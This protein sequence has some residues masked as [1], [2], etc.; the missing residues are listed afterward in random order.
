MKDRFY[1]KSHNDRINGPKQERHENMKLENQKKNF[2]T[3]LF[4]HKTIKVT[5]SM[6]VHWKCTKNQNVKKI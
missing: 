4:S 6:V 3:T 1:K 5:V 2:V